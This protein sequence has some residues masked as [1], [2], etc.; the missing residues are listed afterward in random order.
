MASKL[1]RTKPLNAGRKKGTPNKSTLEAIE[2]AQRLGCNPFEILCLIAL[3]DWQR[4]GYASPT[5]VKSAGDTTYEVDRITVETR[6]KAAAAACDYIFPKRKALDITLK[7]I[8]NSDLAAEA[9][10]RLNEA[11]VVG[12]N[13]NGNGSSGN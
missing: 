12:G 8:A 11:K 13:N 10:R 9:R 6:Q 5:I 2:T 7:D 4:L 1:G 3:G